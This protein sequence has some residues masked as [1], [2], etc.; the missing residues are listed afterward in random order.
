MIHDN[1]CFCTCADDTKATA[2]PRDASPNYR[3]VEFEV[4]G[5]DGVGVEI[6]YVMCCDGYLWLWAMI[7]CWSHGNVD[8]V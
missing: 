5:R 3:R 1:V 2:N 4:Y 7:V 6:H 8:G